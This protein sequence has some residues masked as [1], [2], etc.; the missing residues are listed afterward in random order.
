[1]RVASLRSLAALHHELAVDPL[2]RWFL[3]FAMEKHWHSLDA[4]NQQLQGL[5][6]IWYIAYDQ[7]HLGRSCGGASET[8]P[9]LC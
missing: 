9:K 8:N 3:D 4:E 2:L 1:M 7:F 6:L 5:I